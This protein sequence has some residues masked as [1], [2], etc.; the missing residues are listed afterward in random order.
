MR[1]ARVRHSIYHVEDAELVEGHPLLVGEDVVS[2]LEQRV[3]VPP[4]YLVHLERDERLLLQDVHHGA[5]GQADQP[6]GIANLVAHGSLERDADT[7]CN[8][9]LNQYYTHANY[10]HGYVWQDQLVLHGP[11]GEIA[12]KVVETPLLVLHRLAVVQEPDV[13][14]LPAVPEN[15]KEI[16]LKLALTC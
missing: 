11:D 9:R 10:N 14:L 1:D 5:H 16:G 3:L 6:T 4:E 12:A 7:Y 15:C 8:V 13:G 2:E